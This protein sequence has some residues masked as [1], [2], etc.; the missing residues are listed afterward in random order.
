MCNLTYIVENDNSKRYKK[1]TIKSNNLNI[2]TYIFGCE[3]EFY[4]SSHDK[5]GIIVKELYYISKVDLLVNASSVPAVK[6]ASECMHLKPD[7]TLDNGGWEI[8]IPKCS[9]G[10]LKKYIVSIHALISKYGYTNDDTGLHI[11]I[12]TYDKNGVNLDFYKFALLSNEKRLL[13]SWSTRNQHCYNV[14]DIVNY[15]NKKDSNNIKTKKGRIW[16]LEKVS[17]L[18][19]RLLYLSHYNLSHSILIFYK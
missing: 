15:F 10:D 7:E 6:D 12:S 18:C 1:D 14:M 8:S 17:N 5:F 11:H 19:F 4:L 13:D 3:F 16:N 9:Y 2:E